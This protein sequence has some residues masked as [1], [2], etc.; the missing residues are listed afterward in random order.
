[1]VGCLVRV[2]Q[3][4]SDNPPPACHWLLVSDE[5]SAVGLTSRTFVACQIMEWPSSSPFPHVE[6]RQSLGPTGDIDAGTAALLAA[7]GVKD[8]DFSLEV[9]QSAALRWQHACRFCCT[10]IADF[11]RGSSCRPWS[12]ACMQHL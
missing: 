11:F 12:M 7:E 5:A 9:R 6:V 8:Q 2:K 1:M 3:R 4:P 10:Q